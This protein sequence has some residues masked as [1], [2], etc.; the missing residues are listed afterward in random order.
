MFDR[1]YSFKIEERE[2]VAFVRLLGRFG[3]RFD[4]S[5]VRWSVDSF[6]FK[7][8]FST[9]YSRSTPTPGRW[10]GSVKLSESW[11]TTIWVKL[12]A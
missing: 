5:D 2:T 7:P 9:A 10:R 4:M 1:K 8:R 6:G 3:F 11:Q 12:R